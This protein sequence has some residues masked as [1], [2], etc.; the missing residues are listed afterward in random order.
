MSLQQG[1]SHSCGRRAPRRAGRRERRAGARPAMDL[2]DASLLALAARDAALRETRAALRESQ[3]V[4][5]ALRSELD[6]AQLA[7]GNAERQRDEVRRA[8]GQ[9]PKPGLRGS[10]SE[11][12][13]CAC[14]ALEPIWHDARGDCG[15]KPKSAEQCQRPRKLFN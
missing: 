10:M 12:V 4:T 2:Q 6:E 9:A 15:V 8:T 11:S 1:P 7:A 13:A 5:E 14:V 3:A